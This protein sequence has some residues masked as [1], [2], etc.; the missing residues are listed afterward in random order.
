MF[1]GLF[2]WCGE[3][4]VVDVEWLMWCLGL[5]FYGCIV[6]VVCGRDI[7]MFFFFVGWV[8]LFVSCEFVCIKIVE[9]DWWFC[10]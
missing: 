4:E 9:V 3:E 2:G 1:D 7:L 5:C 6:G 10:C 8:V